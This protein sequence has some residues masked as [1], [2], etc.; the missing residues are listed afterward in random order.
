MVLA[1]VAVA[2]A[3]TACS[4]DN[5]S[6]LQLSGDCTIQSLVLDQYEGTVDLASR[7]VTVRVPETYNTEEMTLAKLE[8]SEGATADLA[9]NDKLNMSVAHSMR[10]PMVTCSSTG[11]SRPC[12]MRLRF[13]PSSSTAHT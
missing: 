7:T 5:T 8:L 3:T 9:V 12:A 1:V 13:S 4:D 10:E 6:D 2:F 11:Q